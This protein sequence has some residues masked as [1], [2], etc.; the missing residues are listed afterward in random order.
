LGIG[1]LAN[2]KRAIVGTTFI[3][4]G[5]FV[6]SGLGIIDIIYTGKGG[7]IGSLLGTL[8]LLFGYAA[9]LVVNF[10][11]LVVAIIITVNIP[12]KLKFKLPKIRREKKRKG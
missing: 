2:I 12:L 1:A 11:L 3:G 7:I 10:T 8:E 6:A 9:S 5:F 4:A